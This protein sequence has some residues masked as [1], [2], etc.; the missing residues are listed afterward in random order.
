MPPLEYGYQ[1]ISLPDPPSS[2][3]RG[4]RI[5]VTWPAINRERLVTFLGEKHPQFQ[6]VLREIGLLSAMDKT[7]GSQRSLLIFQ[8]VLNQMEIIGLDINPEEDS[9]SPS[10]YS[11]GKAAQRCRQRLISAV[12]QLVEC[13]RCVRDGTRGVSMEEAVEI[14]TC[15]WYSLPELDQS[16]LMPLL[17]S[18][19]IVLGALLSTGALGVALDWIEVQFW[20]KVLLVCGIKMDKINDIWIG[21]ECLLQSSC[22]SIDGVSVVEPR[23][24]PLEYGDPF[25]SLPDQPSSVDLLASSARLSSGPTRFG[26]SSDHVGRDLS[27]DIFFLRCWKDQIRSTVF[28]ERALPPSIRSQRNWS[29]RDVTP[30]QDLDFVLDEYIGTWTTEAGIR[31][32]PTLWPREEMDTEFLRLVDYILPNKSNPICRM[33]LKSCKKMSLLLQSRTI[34]TCD[35]EK[36]AGRA[37]F[38]YLSGLVFGKRKADDV[39]VVPSNSLSTLSVSDEEKS[40]VSSFALR[41]RE[42]AFSNNVSLAFEGACIPVSVS[43]ALEDGAESILLVSDAVK[44]DVNHVTPSLSFFS[45]T[46]LPSFNESK[47]VV[48]FAFDKGLFALKKFELESLFVFFWSLLVPFD[49]GK[50]G[51]VVSW[52]SCWHSKILC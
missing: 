31:A 6:N 8:E 50:T 26:K 35:D 10:V 13:F 37:W 27:S 9:A 29:H 3:S 2:V 49:R 21:N 30:A 47:I 25:V 18:A 43:D 4:S 16:N 5:V 22:R 45:M 7:M 32:A 36:G 42:N 38:R 12:H 34:T 48:P 1:P 40:D 15:A 24:P 39:S 52:F 11:D 46:V 20:K 23:M 44:D 33:L 41:A 14:L 51:A 28:A 17:Q 19:G